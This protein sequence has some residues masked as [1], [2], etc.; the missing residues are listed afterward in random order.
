MIF[1]SI[2]E[3]RAIGCAVHCPYSDQLGIAKIEDQVQRGTLNFEIVLSKL[4]FLFLGSALIGTAHGCAH[5][6]TSHPGPDDG[7]DDTAAIQSL[8]D[9]AA[10]RGGGTVRL[11]VGTY[12]ISRPIILRTGVSLIGRGPETVITNEGLNNRDDWFGGTIIAGT[13]SPPMW[14]DNSGLGYPQLDARRLSDKSIEL[15]RCDASLLPKEREIVWLSSA[16]GERQKGGNFRPTYGELN[17]IVAAD[18]CTLTLQDRIIIPSAEALKFARA[19]GS[20]SKPRVAPSVPIADVTIRD[21]QLR[22]AS[23]QA[24]RVT[25]CY[26]CTFE[27][28][29]LGRT[30]RLLMVQGMRHGIYRNIKG[31]FRE[32]GLE[33]TMFTWDNIVEN[34]DARFEFE[35]NTAVSDIRPAVRF[36]EFARGNTVKNVRLD[37]GPRYAKRIKLRFDASG[38]NSLSNI[39]LIA[40]G[41]DDRRTLVVK[42]SGK[43]ASTSMED[44]EETKLDYVR[45]CNEA[46]EVRCTFV[47]R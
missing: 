43:P 40:P 14:S 37:L 45:V 17:R 38:Q 10:E 9:D 29:T 5:A 34:V 24:L 15:M 42:T 3:H 22:S 25:G 23:G 26:S 11:D 33:F 27:N 16:S 7:K 28:L 18:G 2:S 44:L 1:G 47:V 6:D 21:L 31:V 20:K 36:G 41:Y 13:L 39:L 12:N 30:R 4:T 32:R 8:I 35:A 46:G 19:D